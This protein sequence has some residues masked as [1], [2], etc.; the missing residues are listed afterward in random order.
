[1]KGE[2][3]LGLFILFH[4]QDSAEAEP[5]KI[6]FFGFTG[7]RRLRSGFGFGIGF[8]SLFGSRLSDV[9]YFFVCCRNA[10]KCFNMG[11]A[12]PLLCIIGHKAFKTNGKTHLRSN[13][14]LRIF[15]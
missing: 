3:G 6:R 7:N 14:H 13:E 12:W 11:Q 10:A 8:R 1:M 15:V 5:E 9:L 4:R 2:E